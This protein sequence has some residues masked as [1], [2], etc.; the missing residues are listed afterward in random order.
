MVVHITPCIESTEIETGIHTFVVRTGSIVG[1]ICIL[2][3]LRPTTQVGIPV[4]VLHAFT[5]IVSIL[6]IFVNCIVSA[7]SGRE[8]GS[9]GRLL[10]TTTGRVGIPFVFRQTTANCVTQI[11]IG[12]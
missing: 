7:S 11:G 1:T 4:K 8:I 2:N 6:Q 9:C 5:Q 12:V 10:S 3:T